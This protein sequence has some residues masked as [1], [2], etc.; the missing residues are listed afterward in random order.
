MTV[1]NEKHFNGDIGKIGNI[2]TQKQ[3]AREVLSNTIIIS[4]EQ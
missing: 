3:Q 2:K 4:K 1:K